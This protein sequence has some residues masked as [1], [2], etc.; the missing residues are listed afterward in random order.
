MVEHCFRGRGFSCEIS[1][2]GA[3]GQLESGLRLV[4]TKVTRGRA[5]VKSSL[6]RGWTRWGQ[7]VPWCVGRTVGA[8]LV[9]KELL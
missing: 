7:P 3:G 8:I 9:Q 1:A 5:E 4:G 2:A 6:R